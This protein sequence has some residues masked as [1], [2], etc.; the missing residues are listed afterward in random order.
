MSLFGITDTTPCVNCGHEFAEHDYVPTSIDQYRCPVPMVHHGY[1]FFCGGD[2]RKFHPDGECSSPE[3]IENHRKA[4]EQAEAVE[5]GRDLPCPSGWEG[6][7]D[8]GSVHVTR[9]PFGLGMYTIE[10]ES[11]FEARESDDEE[12]D[13]EIESAF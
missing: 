7:P 10:M 5:S 11:F 3:E 6:T 2:P 4:C 1:G 8:G 12:S 9:A 13:D